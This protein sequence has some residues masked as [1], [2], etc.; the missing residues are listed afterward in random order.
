VF[1]AK[2]RADCGFESVNELT[3]DK[4]FSVYPN[5][6]S[7]MFT[8]NS[9][10]TNGE[11]SICNVLGE[12]VFSSKINSSVTTIDLSDAA[13]GIYFVNVRTEKGSFTEKIIIQ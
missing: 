3:D 5:P 7:G 8:L 9:K 1:V 10:I 2:F 11:I 12:I 13:G 4:S 6:S